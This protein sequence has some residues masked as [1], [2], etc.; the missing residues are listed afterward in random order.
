LT[1]GRDGTIVTATDGSRF[2]V[3]T[4]RNIS[5][6]R[7]AAGQNGTEQAVKSRVAESPP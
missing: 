5:D 2:T 3:S 1:T 6:D 7:R 4:S